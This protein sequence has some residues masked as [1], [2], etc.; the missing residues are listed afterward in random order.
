MVTTSAAPNWVRPVYLYLVCLV[1]NLVMIYGAVTF[2]Q[3]V[4]NT[5]AP[6]TDA[7]PITQIG[8]AVIDVV[9]DVAGGLPDV[10]PEFERG[11]A[12]ARH[13]LDKQ[14]RNRGVTR[15][16]T[17]GTVFVVGLAAFLLAWRRAEGLSGGGGAPVVGPVAWPASAQ[18]VAPS[19]AP[20][21]W[22]PPGAPQAPPSPPPSAPAPPAAP[23][24]PL[25]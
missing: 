13:A 17:G 16:V 25:T 7:S 6:K 15:M 8:N 1:G 9:A 22:A 23:S 3:G 12:T 11:V 2:V 18:Y 24:P 21:P 10:P 4:V 14:A 20:S 5:A 19:A